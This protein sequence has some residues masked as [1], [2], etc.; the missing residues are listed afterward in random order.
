MAI[1]LGRWDCPVCGQEGILG[2]ITACASCGSTRGKDV[3]FYLPDDAENINDEAKLDENSIK[4]TITK[5]TK[6]VSVN[7]I[8]KRNRNNKS[9]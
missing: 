9:R 1:Q 8:S 5:N 6:I 2:N 3:E 7:H 4:E